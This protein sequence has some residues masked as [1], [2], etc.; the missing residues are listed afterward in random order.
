MIASPPD[1]QPLSIVLLD[2]S[3]QQQNSSGKNLAN[4]LTRFIAVSKICP[5]IEHQKTL[6]SFNIL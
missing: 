5:N 2:H 1:L 3:I 4:H 6:R